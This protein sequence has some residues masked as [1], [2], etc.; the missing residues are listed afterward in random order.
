[1]TSVA[2]YMLLA[3]PDAAARRHFL[4]HHAENTELDE[5]GR[6]VD[7]I[8]VESLLDQYGDGLTPMGALKDSFSRL[9]GAVDR[10][11]DIK[12]GSQFFVPHDWVVQH[13]VESATEQALALAK[14]DIED[15]LN[16]LV[17]PKPKTAE[18]WVLSDE[19]V[20]A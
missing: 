19:A 8:Y 14:Q 15:A 9:V 17:P 1:M 13:G 12:S 7:R 6:P 11:R 16:E 20:S 5:D 3:L 4:L 18:A 10:Y 2:D